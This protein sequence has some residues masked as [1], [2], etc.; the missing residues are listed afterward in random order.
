[1]KW[2]FQMISCGCGSMLQGVK[3][4]VDADEGKLNKKVGTSRAG[5]KGKGK[6]GGKRQ[7]VLREVKCRWLDD[8]VWEKKDEVNRAQ[9]NILGS[10]DALKKAQAEGKLEEGVAYELKFRDGGGLRLI[11]AEPKWRTGGVEYILPETEVIDELMDM[12]LADVFPHLAKT[13]AWVQDEVKKNSTEKWIL[14]NYER[15]C[16]ELDGV[17]TSQ[18]ATAKGSSSLTKGMGKVGGNLHAN[19][20]GS[21]AL[22][23][24]EL[25]NAMLK[26]GKGGILDAAREQV[27][28]SMALRQGKGKAAMARREIEEE[29]A[30]MTELQKAETEEERKRLAYL[31]KVKMDAQWSGWD[32]SVAPGGKGASMHGDYAYASWEEFQWWQQQKQEIGAVA[33]GAAGFKGWDDEADVDSDGEDEDADGEE[34]E[35]MPEGAVEYDP[36][37]K[38]WV[39]EWG[40]PIDPNN[41]KKHSEVVE[42]KKEVEGSDFASM[43]GSKPTVSSGEGSGAAG[44]TADESG[45]TTTAS[46]PTEGS[47]PEGWTYEKWQMHYAERKAKEA[48]ELGV[49]GEDDDEELPDEEEV[50]KAKALKQ[51]R[52]AAAGDD[53]DDLVDEDGIGGDS[54]EK[55]D[56]E[57]DADADAETKKKASA[58]AWNYAGFDQYG[59]QS[60][61]SLY[62]QQ[63]GWYDQWGQWQDA[64][65]WQGAGAGAAAGAA[66]A[67]KP[68]AEKSDYT[69]FSPKKREDPKD[70][71]DDAF[72]EE[73]E[74]SRAANALASVLFSGNWNPIQLGA[75]TSQNA[76]GLAS[77]DP[78]IIMNDPN[79]QAVVRA[80]SVVKEKRNMAA[81]ARVSAAAAV[82]PAIIVGSPKKE[83]KPAL[84]PDVLLQ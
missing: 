4:M 22:K 2:V 61:Y 80:P 73:E 68:K 39:D 23:S 77:V 66:A 33:P 1:M 56:D 10:L 43:E 75:T 34:K 84:S 38:A 60:D 52:A 40:D 18:Q 17:I 65:A 27:L 42:E 14:S 64:A 47:Q 70:W 49:T 72:V 62:A 6:S 78:A 20:D 13:D 82:D 25:Q 16:D 58:A 54:D 29:L 67:T 24:A 51:A 45:E 44:A 37:A 55:V 15:L 7:A 41:P 79:F 81:A 48:K 63:G 76:S 32:P 57:V 69:K 74:D 12:E 9:Q 8:L 30:E 11:E 36:A 83:G 31:H 26:G 46:K 50:D 5:M 35:E 71:V 21:A 53:D 59:R 3:E 19:R 28:E